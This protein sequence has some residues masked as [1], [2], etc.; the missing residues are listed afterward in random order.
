MGGGDSPLMYDAL[1]LLFCEKRY[2]QTENRG[3]LGLLTLYPIETHLNTCTFANKT[4]SDQAVIVRAAQLG[5]T[6]FA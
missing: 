1:Y 2:V 5:S 4:Y 6:L 3:P